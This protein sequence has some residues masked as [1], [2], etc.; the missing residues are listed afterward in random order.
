MM[1][2]PRSYGTFPRVLGRYVR[3]QGLLTLEAAVRKMTCLPATIFGMADRGLLQAGMA[4]DV[5]AFDPARVLDLAD[6]AKPHRYPEGI[7]YVLVNGTPA[8]A[9]GR[10]TGDGQ[11]EVLRRQRSGTR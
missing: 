8:V 10:L 9:G 5:V 3:E 6:F 4:A 2:H 11:G 1:V 7:E